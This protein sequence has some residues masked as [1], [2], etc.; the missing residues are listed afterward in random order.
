MN[1]HGVKKDYAT[2]KC[3]LEKAA[4]MP[5]TGDR[6]HD[7]GVAD[8]QYQLGDAYITGLFGEKSL[9]KGMELLDKAAK[10]GQAGALNNLGSLYE[11]GKVVGQNKE[12]AHE[13]YLAAA[14][15]GST[16]AMQNLATQYVSGSGVPIDMAKAE[17]WAQ[18]A[19]DNG[20]MAIEPL[21]QQIQQSRRRGEQELDRMGV[22]EW[23]RKQGLENDGTDMQARINRYLK[24]ND[25][26]GACLFFI[27]LFYVIHLIV[28]EI[29]I[30]LA[31][32]RG[33]RVAEVAGGGMQ[34]A[35][36]VACGP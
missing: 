25:K 32:R 29:F 18:R 17:Q 21:L 33:C 28:K 5:K 3:L 1:G 36:Q 35:E 16:I 30:S 22:R 12:Q 20:N 27:I 13:Y 2:A 9:E 14:A 31:C 19:L 26:S 34:G 15:K 10:A 6:Q 7:S 4:A 8:A 23:E 24:H 11:H